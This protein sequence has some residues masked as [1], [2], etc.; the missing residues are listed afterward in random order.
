MMRA[1][2]RVYLAR[3]GET[4]WNRSRRW[5]GHADTHLNEAGLTQARALGRRLAALGIE[6]I[7]TS[8]LARARETAVLVGEAVGVTP[9]AAPDLREVDVGSWAG[10][11]REAARARDPEGYRRWLAGA[12]GWSDGE[13]YEALHER[14][15][16]AFERLT[17]DQ[18]ERTLL[19]LTH[20]GP[21]RAIV[22][23]ALGLPPTADRRRIAGGANCSLSLLHR[24]ASGI[25]LSI[26]NDEGHL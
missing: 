16:A 13:T 20:N 24:H 12:T 3:H 19:L 17:A 8:D 4:D 7:Y 6:K 14:A 5:Q 11:T 22:S 26:L 25:T 2:T 18:P 23:H 9:V 1:M 21:I 10:L 15:V